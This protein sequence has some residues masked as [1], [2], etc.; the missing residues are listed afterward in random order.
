MK[1]SQLRMISIFFSF[2]LGRLWAWAFD[3]RLLVP[4]AD[5]NDFVSLKQ[6]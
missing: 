2:N 6:T 5:R 1:M 3:A 4:Y